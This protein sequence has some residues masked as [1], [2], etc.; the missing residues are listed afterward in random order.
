MRDPGFLPP[1]FMGVEIAPLPIPVPWP[2]AFL[3]EEWRAKVKEIRDRGL[4]WKARE[5]FRRRGGQL[6]CNVLVAMLNFVVM[7]TPAQWQDFSFTAVEPTE[8]QKDILAG[9]TTECISCA[10]TE[11]NLLAADRGR[12]RLHELIESVKHS[13]GQ[14]HDVE[15]YVCSALNID[16]NN[17][18]LPS[19]AGN[20]RLADCLPPHRATVARSL[21]SLQLPPELQPP[22][23]MRA[24]HK[25]LPHDEVRFV[26]L[27]LSWGMGA[28]YPI[29]DV[30]RDA[31]GRRFVG[32]WF[33]VLSGSKLRLIFDRR[34]QNARERRL[35]CL[36]LPLGSQFR[37]LLRGPPN[38]VRASIDDVE[39]CFFQL[40]TE[41]E[42][43]TL[44]AAGRVL[45]G[46]DFVDF[47]A[48]PSTRYFFCL[49]VLAMG[50]Q[51]S[52]D[53]AEEANE[54]ILVSGGCLLPGETL[55]YRHPEPKGS[56]WEGVYC[57][58]HL[59]AEQLPR[60]AAQCISTKPDPRR[61]C[62][63]GAGCLRRDEEILVA[64]CAAY[65]RVGARRSEE[66]AT[67]YVI[68]D[69]KG[70]GTHVNG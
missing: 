68:K 14:H 29:T 9:L 11:G 62:C 46:A 22:R 60:E 25:V 33:C 61:P 7:D 32:G 35:K 52:F 55:R 44:N 18:K 5:L 19:Q 15:S 8:L 47:G 28:L 34:P 37:R 23:A 2:E 56:T 42:S 54:W 16:I 41:P 70:W 69:I 31:R 59:V 12:A 64:S 66:K 45:Y 49:G 1:N 17:L 57:D 67:R 38:V 50:G 48:D 20:L 30:P 27:L 58:D 65:D 6:Y 26:K 39:V 36:R 24:C 53:L 13:C 43:H 40:A 21:A 10:E 51:N 4:R 3:I 63:H